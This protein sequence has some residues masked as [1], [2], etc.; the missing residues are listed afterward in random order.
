MQRGSNAKLGGN[1]RTQGEEEGQSRGGEE[2]RSSG[3]MGTEEN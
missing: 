2:E 3:S 1:A